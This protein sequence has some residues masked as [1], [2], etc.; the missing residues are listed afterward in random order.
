MTVKAER[1]KMHHCGSKDGERGHEARTVGQTPEAGRA[2]A[3][4]LPG[5]SRGHPVLPAL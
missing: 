5:T 4:I 3:Q 2:R 1:L